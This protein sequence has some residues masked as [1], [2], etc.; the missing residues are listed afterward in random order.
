MDPRSLD[1]KTAVFSF[2]DLTPECGVRGHEMDESTRELPLI[3]GRFAGRQWIVEDLQREAEAKPRQTGRPRRRAAA[4]VVCAAMAVLLLVG[5]LM[6]QAR[7]TALNDQAV[8][9]SGEIRDLRQERNVLMAEYA[10]SEDLAAAD[11]YATVELGMQ[12]P[13]SDQLIAPGAGAADKATVLGVR[14]GQGLSYLWNSFIDDLGSY[15][16]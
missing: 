6:A 8:A 10:L 15:L 7:L 2:G 1:Q 13:R 4:L 9:V 3:A 11:R 16:R 12:Q 14:R 5:A